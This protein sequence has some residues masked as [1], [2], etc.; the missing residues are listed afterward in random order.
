MSYEGR[1]QILCKNGHYFIE[2]DHNGY[3]NQTET[4][5]ECGEPIKWMNSVDDTNCEAYGY[6]DMEQ[7]LAEP[8]VIET[9]NL[10]HKHITKRAKY[11]IPSDQEMAQFNTRSWARN[12][13]KN[14]ILKWDWRR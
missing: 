9:C 5:P 2:N 10:G 7:F 8:A 12:Q 14:K 3:S 6:I 1:F 13:R 11:R 4:C